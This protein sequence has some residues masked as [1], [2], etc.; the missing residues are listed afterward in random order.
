MSFESFSCLFFRPFHKSHFPRIN[1]TR[2]LLLGSFWIFGSRA[3]ACSNTIQEKGIIIRQPRGRRPR[4]PLFIPNNFCVLTKKNNIICINALSQPD[5]YVR[6]LSENNAAR[7]AKKYFLF[8][9]YFH[10]EKTWRLGSSKLIDKNLFL[11]IEKNILS[12]LVFFLL[13]HCGECFE[14]NNYQIIGDR[15]YITKI[16]QILYDK[17]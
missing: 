4:K 8:T 2:L 1:M 16:G 13:S 15:Y 9:K 11:E 7:L 14:N 5:F 6:S 12:L 3:G 10:E 17:Q